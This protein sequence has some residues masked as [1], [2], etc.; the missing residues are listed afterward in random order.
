MSGSDMYLNVVHWVERERER[1]RE[2]KSLTNE[3]C[4]L[5]PGTNY[6]EQTSITFLCIGLGLGVIRIKIL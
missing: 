3:K 4:T 6:K 2:N 5:I 1:E